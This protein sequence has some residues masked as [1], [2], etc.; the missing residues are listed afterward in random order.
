MKKILAAAAGLLA[1]AA[2]PALAGPAC[3]ELA[4]VWNY[5]AL[6]DKTLI[7]E[8]EA[9]RKFKLTLMGYCPNLPYKQRLGFKVFGGTELSCISKGDEVISRDFGF[10]YRCPI[11]DIVAYTPA[12]EQADKAAAAAKAQQPG[13]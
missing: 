7:V 9:H 5:K 8:D 1:L 12:M 6:N 11:M 2:P 13:H 4:L 3:L 10:P